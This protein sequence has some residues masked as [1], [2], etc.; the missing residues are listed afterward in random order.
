M[1]GPRRWIGPIDRADVDRVGTGEV[2]QARFVVAARIILVG[3]R[4]RGDLELDLVEL[5]LVGFEQRQPVAHVGRR[6]AQALD[7]GFRELDLAMAVLETRAQALQVGL[8]GLD[9]GAQLATALHQVAPR[10]VHR[11]ELELLLALRE[12]D[13]VLCQVSLDRVQAVEIDLRGAARGEHFDVLGD[14]LVQCG[15]DQARRPLRILVAEADLQDARIDG[16]LDLHVLL[17]Q[18][19][20]ALARRLCIEQARL[21]QPRSRRFDGSA[22]PAR[23]L[24]A[25][26]RAKLV[27]D[28]GHH[29]A[30]DEDLRFGVQGLGEVHRGLQHRAQHRR[31][32]AFDQHPRT[33]DVAGRRQEDDERGSACDQEKDAQEAGLPLEQEDEKVAFGQGVP[34]V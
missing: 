32:V 19:D 10:L 3:A 34:S 6:C 14:V 17:Q 28:V 1:V 33:G 8:C 4:Q 22:E 2:D 15:V 24:R 23:L 31:P 27:D 16:G 21:L 9:L 7:L 11:R 30:R 29:R 26:E 20:P 18:L 25:V 13:P 12:F 5:A